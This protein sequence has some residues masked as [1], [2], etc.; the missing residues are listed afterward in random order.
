ML[1]LLAVRRL[2]VEGRLVLLVPIPA[3]TSTADAF[4]ADL[5]T[6]R[7]LRLEHTSRQRISLRMHR[8]LVTLVKQRA[9]EPGELEE[10][11]DQRVI[12]DARARSD[13]SPWAR[14]WRQFDPIDLG[15]CGGANVARGWARRHAPAA[16]SAGKER[17]GRE[18][19]ARRREE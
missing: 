12:E 17:R 4:P 7:W 10:V 8:L 5:P 13:R 6:A 15:A 14:W 18:L 11:D 3:A 16:S 19:S 2:R 1:L 9:T